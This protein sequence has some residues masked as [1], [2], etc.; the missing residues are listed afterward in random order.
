VKRIVALAQGT[1]SSANCRGVVESFCSQSKFVDDSQV[2]NAPRNSIRRKR[3]RSIT[4]SRSSSGTQLG[5]DKALTEGDVVGPAVAAE[6]I[7][8][9]SSLNP[10]MDATIRGLSGLAPRTLAL[11]HG[12]SFMGDDAAALRALADDYDRSVSHNPSSP[13]A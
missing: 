3:R 9:H 11:M 12:P 1:F 5:N 10:G 2:H 13:A 8:K 4:T 6:D 7:F